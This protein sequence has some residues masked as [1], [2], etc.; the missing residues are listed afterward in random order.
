MYS[1]VIG[2]PF[3]VFESNKP[4]FISL[5]SSLSGMN[6]ETVSS[7][8]LYHRGNMVKLSFRTGSKGN[9]FYRRYFMSNVK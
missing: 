3:Y 2:L 6:F 5:Y 7:V 9:R 8:Y 1:S 4:A